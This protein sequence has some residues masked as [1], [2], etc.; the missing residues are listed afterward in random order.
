MR[1]AFEVN[2]RR[3]RGGNGPTRGICR[4]MRPPPFQLGTPKTGEQSER[5]ANPITQASMRALDPRMKVSFERSRL[6]QGNLGFLIVTKTVGIHG[7]ITGDIAYLPKLY[8][9]RLNPAASGL[10]CGGF[11]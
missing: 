2:S 11:N 10:R 7:I 4:A 3:G 1:I 6:V 8:E 9:P 5:D